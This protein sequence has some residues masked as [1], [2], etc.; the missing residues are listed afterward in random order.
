MDEFNQFDFGRAREVDLIREVKCR[1]ALEGELLHLGL[2][3]ILEAGLKGDTQIGV[4][5]EFA[6]ILGGTQI[7]VEVGPSLNFALSRSDTGGSDRE[8]ER[9]NK[10]DQ[11]PE[12]QKSK[13]ALEGSLNPRN[14]G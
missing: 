14:H 6:L 7:Q 1:I 11:K 4:D 9:D 5:V 10:D 13:V 2:R 8:N 12:K 3:D